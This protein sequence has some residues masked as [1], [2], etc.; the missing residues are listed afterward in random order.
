MEEGILSGCKEIFFH[1]EVPGKGTPF[2][3]RLCSLHPGE[4]LTTLKKIYINI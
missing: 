2:S 3:E 1:P 4:D